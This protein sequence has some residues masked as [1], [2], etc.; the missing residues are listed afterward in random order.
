MRA[1]PVVAGLTVVAA[2]CCWGRPQRRRRAGDRGGGAGRKRGGP[3]QRERGAGQPRGEGSRL[4]RPPGRWAGGTAFR[5]TAALQAWQQHDV[6]TAGTAGQF[7]RRSSEGQH[8]RSLCHR[9][10][11]LQGPHC[12]G[13]AAYSP[14]GRRIV[15]ASQDKT[16]KVLDE[17]T[18]SGPAHP[19]RTRRGRRA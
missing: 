12:P 19:S 7:P 2:R 5:M 16:L 10:V 11:W 6:L 17:Q 4:R 1:T 14:D 8:L 18:G 15:S 3:C 9:K 13:T